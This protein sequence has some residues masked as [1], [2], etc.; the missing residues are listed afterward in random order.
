[1]LEQWLWHLQ[2]HGSEA[3]LS[4]QVPLHACSVGC[5]VILVGL[6][7]VYVVYVYKPVRKNRKPASSAYKLPSSFPQVQ[8]RIVRAQGMDLG[9]Q[10]GC[11]ELTWL[12]G[13]FGGSYAGFTS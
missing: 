8:N 10:S 6:V 4:L 11:C 13:H 1:M 9:L 7:S 2:I 5:T 12:S 3:G